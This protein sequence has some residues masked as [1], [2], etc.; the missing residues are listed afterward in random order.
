M[1][2]PVLNWRRRVDETFLFQDSG[3]SDLLHY[4]PRLAWR[5]LRRSPFGDRVL[6]V[7]DVDLG[8][9]A[10][11]LQA[12]QAA[13]PRQRLTTARWFSTSSWLPPTPLG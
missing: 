11:E 7:G 2:R 8:Y 6:F 3:D 9:E 4:G 12:L 10:A 13:V 1:P 5:T